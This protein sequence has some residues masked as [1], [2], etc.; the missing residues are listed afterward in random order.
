MVIDAEKRKKELL[1][2]NERSDGPLFKMRDDPR[3]TKVGRILRKYSLDE[4]PQLVNVLKG[5]LSIVGPR[6]HLPEEVAAY[7]GTDYLRLECMPGI[8]CLPQV[9]G[10][11]SLSFREWVDYDLKYRHNWSNILDV[12]IMVQAVRVMLEPLVARKNPGY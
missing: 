7:M 2:Y 11:N 5:D 4:V 10:R 1:Q 8:V 9:N 6:P 12:K 3:I